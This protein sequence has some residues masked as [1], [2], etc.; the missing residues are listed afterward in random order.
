EGV[1]DPLECA[2]KFRQKAKE[3]SEK[4][5]QQFARYYNKKHRDE[6]FQVDDLVLLELERVKKIGPRYDGPYRI[7]EIKGKNC[8]L[9]PISRK[10]ATRL[11]TVDKLKFYRDYND[12]FWRKSNDP[13]Q[14]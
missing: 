12:C 4:A 13:H 11:A 14:S 5:Q 9:A 3:L 8:I 7:I 2:M 10:K 1:N 6:K